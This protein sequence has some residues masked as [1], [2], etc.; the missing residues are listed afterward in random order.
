MTLSRTLAAFLL[1]SSL[2]LAEDPV[3]VASKQLIAAHQDSL[4]S[5]TAVVKMSMSGGGTRGAPQ[6]R[7][8]DS[9]GTVIDASGLVVTSLTRLDP[10]ALMASMGGGMRGIESSIQ[11]VKVV[12]GDGTEIPG[13]IVLKDADLDLAFVRADT[14]SK[15]AKGIK[16]LPIDLADSTKVSPGEG[17]IGLARADETVGRVPGVR[18]DH[19]FTVAKRPREFVLVS[20]TDFL[21]SP[22][23]TESGKLV[24]IGILRPGR[25][26]N[27][28]ST[29]IAVAD[30]VKE[31]AEQAKAAKPKPPVAKKDKEPKA[32]EAAPKVESKPE[33]KPEPKKAEA[34]AQ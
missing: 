16:F 29:A 23:Y 15:E 28:S 25:S 22:V 1:F 30:D 24:G 7:K 19:V 18:L 6:E 20:S 12:M 26:V 9:P 33:A 32:E 13:Q 17:L 10:T 31:V 8:M 5:I 2:A 3:V 11:E 27:R 34:S 14:T 21:G 4:V